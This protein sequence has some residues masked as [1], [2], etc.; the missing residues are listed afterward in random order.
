[1]VIQ[2]ALGIFLGVLFLAILAGVIVG[3]GYIIGREQDVP[4]FIEEPKKK[5][6]PTIQD[7]WDRY[8]DDEDWK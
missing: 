1:M 6:K 4:G 3:I 2:I 7:W 8:D 5:R